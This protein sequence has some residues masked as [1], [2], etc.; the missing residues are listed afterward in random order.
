LVFKNI[1]FAWMIIQI[2]C[3]VRVYLWYFA[4]FC[5]VN[6]KIAYQYARQAILLC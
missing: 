4:L 3:K 1:L 5:W 6:A 2:W